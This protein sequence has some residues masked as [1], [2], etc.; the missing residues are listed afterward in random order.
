MSRRRKSSSTPLG[1]VVNSDV[2][3]L[4]A[5]LFMSLFTSMVP[6]VTLSSAVEAEEV[7]EAEESAEL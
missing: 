3:A 5:L 4:L 2:W 6:L 1:L 7:V